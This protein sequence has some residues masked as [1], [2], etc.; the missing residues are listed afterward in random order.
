MSQ[1]HLLHLMMMAAMEPPMEMEA[2][3][4]GNEKV[5]VLNSIRPMAPNPVRT[6]SCRAPYTTDTVVGES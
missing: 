6:Q 2:E 3:A 5:K 4:L 1:S